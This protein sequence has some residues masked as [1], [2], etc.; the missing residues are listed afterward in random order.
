MTAEA[1][2]YIIN[3]DIY[4]WVTIDDVYNNLIAMYPDN[5]LLRSILTD[6]IGK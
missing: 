1:T 3:T 4:T 6:I 5:R 2:L